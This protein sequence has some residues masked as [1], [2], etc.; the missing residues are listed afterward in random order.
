[1]S[2]LGESTL[3]QCGGV[4]LSAEEQELL[5]LYH[6]S[7]DDEYVDL[8]LIMDLLHN[9]CSTSSDGEPQHLDFKNTTAYWTVYF[10]ATETE[11]CLE[12][13]AMNHRQISVNIHDISGLLQCEP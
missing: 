12:T 9:I 1:M 5:K 7:F 8:D 13:M 4:E 3:V 10:M 11:D 2:S 6:H